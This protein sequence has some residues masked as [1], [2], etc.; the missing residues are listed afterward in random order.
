VTAILTGRGRGRR[1]HFSADHALLPLNSLPHA[2]TKQRDSSNF[3]LT[4]ARS[5]HNDLN[6]SY[7][8]KKGE[9]VRSK[10]R[11]K[12]GDLP[13]LASGRE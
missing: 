12:R 11:A 8:G 6:V 1:F 3:D 4:G 5:E 2:A 13:A 7:D 10:H 9:S